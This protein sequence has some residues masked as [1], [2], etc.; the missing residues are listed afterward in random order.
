MAE[1]K[2]KIVVA[3]DTNSSL[4]QVVTSYLQRK[5]L[6]DKYEVVIA[7]DGFATLTKAKEKGVALLITETSLKRY[8]AAE[9]IKILRSLNYTNL[10]IIRLSEIFGG[11]DPRSCEYTTGTG[12]FEENF[13][14]QSHI[15]P[16]I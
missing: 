9:I 6:T 2:K 15:F 10:Q 13:K 8:G 4:D 1:N 12:T 5:N 11:G 7:K 3:E 16:V 14:L